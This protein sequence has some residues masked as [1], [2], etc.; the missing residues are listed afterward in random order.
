[1]IRLCDILS[2][3]NIAV[4]SYDP[5]TVF[6]Y[7]CTVTLTLEIL[8]WPKVMA[9]HWVMESNCVNYKQIQQSEKL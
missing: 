7:M 2:R 6:R 4:R 8:P 3:S 1:M 5:D 9:H